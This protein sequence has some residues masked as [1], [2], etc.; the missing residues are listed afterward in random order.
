MDPFLIN[1]IDLA[2]FIGASQTPEGRRRKLIKLY[3]ADAQQ[4]LDNGDM[5]AYNK[6]IEAIKALEKEG[7]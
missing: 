4:A 1:P 2:P 5:D 3:K 6:I 7:Q